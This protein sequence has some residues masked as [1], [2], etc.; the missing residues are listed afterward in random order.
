MQNRLQPSEIASYLTI[1]TSE[2]ILDI[3]EGLKEL[4][5]VAESTDEL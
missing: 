5:G 4:E 1:I 2:H 3:L